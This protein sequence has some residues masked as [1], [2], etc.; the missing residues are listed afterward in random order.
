MNLMK[1]LC[2]AGGVG[3]T[4]TQYAR[5]VEIV[6]AYDLAVGI[7]LGAHQVC[8]YITLGILKLFAKLG[9]WV[10]LEYKVSQTNDLYNFILVA[11]QPNTW[12]YYEL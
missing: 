1:V 10:E 4:N 5:L 9:E 8:N 7:A 2:V 6:G 3:L 11:T 12:K